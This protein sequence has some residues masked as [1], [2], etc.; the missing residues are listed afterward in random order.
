MTNQPSDS[1]DDIFER[2]ISGKTLFINRNVLRNEFIPN[3]IHFRD[4]QIRGVAQIL[5]PALTGHKPSSLLI[6]G[7]TGT[8]KTVVTKY[9]LKRMAEKSK[10][11]DTNVRTAYVNTRIASTEYRILSK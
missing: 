1:L 6:Y 3:Q 11:I 7:K 4:A 9:V 5:S 8:G 10:T 2:A